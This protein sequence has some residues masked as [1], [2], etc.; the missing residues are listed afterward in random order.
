M[1]QSEDIKYYTFNDVINTAL[2]KP[3]SNANKKDY[4]GDAEFSLNVISDLTYSNIW[5]SFIKWCTDQTELGY[6]VNIYSFGNMFYVP[7]KQKKQNEGISVKLTD[8]FLREHNLKWNEAKSTYESLYSAKYENTQ[9]Q[10]EKLNY[11]IISTELNTKKILI[12]N[13][14]NNLFN[15]IG[16]LLESTPNCLID[17]GILGQFIS[18]NKVVHQIPSKLKSDS[19]SNKKTTIKSLIDRAPKSKVNEEEKNEEKKL[20]DFDEKDQE[21]AMMKEKIQNDINEYSK[22]NKAKNIMGTLDEGLSEQEKLEVLNAKQVI[23]DTLKPNNLNKSSSNFK[24]I[25]SEE[26]EEHKITVGPVNEEEKMIIHSKKLPPVKRKKPVICIPMREEKWNIIDMFH[27]DF[28]VERVQKEK[29]N[30]VLFNVYSNTKAAPFTAEKTQI[31]IAHRIGSFYSLS[32]QNFIID[33]TTK[34]IKRLT[35]DYFFKYRNVKFEEPATETEEYLYLLNNEKVSA[36]KI[37]LKKDAHRRYINF[38]YNSINDEYIADMKGD[39][40]YEIIKM[41]NRVYL[42]KHYDELIKVSFGQM[43]QD[44]KIAMKTSILDY[45]LKHPEQRE[46]LNIPISFRR[47]KEYAEEQVQRPSDGDFEWKMNWNKNKLSI[48]NNLYIMCE[49]ATKIMNYFV[50]KLT[51]TSYIKLSD[52]TGDNWPTVKLNKF[53]EN[54]RNQI[55]EEKTLVN[56]KWRKFVENILKENK[57]YK[58]QLII[59]FKSISGLMSSELRKLIIGSINQYYT[60]IKQFKQDKYLTAEDIF[61]SQFD[62]DTI[63]QRSFIEVELKEDPSGEKFTFSDDLETIEKDLTDIVNEIIECSKNVERPDNMFIKNVGKHA[64]LWQI[65]VED[66]EV[67][68]MFTEITNI[69]SENLK[70]ISKAT[71]LYKPFE[72]VMKEK[73]EIEKFIAGAPKRDDFKK[74]IQFYEDK[75][76]LLN[77]MPNYLYMNLIKIN[78]TE[79]NNTIRTKIQNSISDCLKSILSTNILSKGKTLGEGCESILN[80]LKTQVTSEEV[81]YNLETKAEQCRSETIPNLLNEYEDFLEWVFFY[82]SY[83][84]YK[85]LEVQSDTNVNNSFEQSIKSCR[86]NF[87]QIDLS[88]K[89]F[90]EVLENQKKK[91]TQELDDERAKLLEEITKLKA[92]VVSDKENIKDK[93]YD[94][95]K[96]LD[97]ICKLNEWAL[98]CQSRLKKVVE[99]EGFLGNPFT[100]EDERVEQ[101]LSDLAPMI[102]YFTFINNYKVAA[103]KVRE[104]SIWQINFA[105]LDE[106]YN[107]YELFDI[108]MHK[109]P[110]IKD[111]IQRAKAEFESFK[112]TF[113]L[114][115]II[116]PLVSIFQ[117]EGIDEKEIYQDNKIYCN[118]MA[119]Y[120]QGCLIKTE[121]DEDYQNAFEYLKF[122]DIQKYY[123]VIDQSRSDI[124]KVVDEWQIINNM[125]EIEPKMVTEIDIEFSLEKYNQKEYYIISKESFE[126]VLEALKKNINLVDEKLGELKDPR[127]EIIVVKTFKEMKGMMVEMQKI[128]KQL[129]EV[130]ISL[131]KLMDQSAQIKKKYD[132]H[133]LLKQAEKQYK[134]LMDIII[135]KKHKIKGVYFEK[136]KFIERIGELTK[137]FNDIN[138]NLNDI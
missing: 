137:L 75:R 100:T 88:M 16:Y 35:D 119:K 5:N 21:T 109:I 96:F 36:E 86:D 113:E 103:K 12:Q 28:K 67:K 48:S 45:I 9:P 34:S 76:E 72:F 120:F 27:V 77:Q 25:L 52:V 13:G 73:E 70:I 123:K 117:E 29:A 125:Y 56:E 92:E 74:R 49:N 106:F 7:E 71:D 115:K 132:C 68:E 85:V 136:D 108:S 51:N 62:P 81:L 138:K 99:K 129:Q 127:D 53:S 44:Y 57:I 135:S 6:L 79:L 4:L 124:E 8:F 89:S 133:V 128:I 104:D 95:T 111:R 97:E 37:E 63:F 43:T 78:C 66:S 1:K 84:T 42:M 122:F 17:L 22:E 18:T 121:E 41:I 107:Q 134:G 11:I 105:E 33:K 87:I 80:D 102:K 98:N 59:Y 10:T 58:D 82:L 38:I 126:K 3:G 101:C 40:L 94:L 61:N 90:N 116:F 64:N 23:K 39:W 54:Q 24:N 31:P 110:N 2:Q 20:E 14:L 83:D 112:I 47:I 69:I 60:F 93:I 91:F 30:P 19:V 15:A 32:L 50:T 65:T 131:E 118:E 55:E 130:Q 46:K 26:V 114:A